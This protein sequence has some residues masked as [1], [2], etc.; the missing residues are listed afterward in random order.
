[1]SPAPHRHRAV[2]RR[3]RRRAGDT[4][5]HRRWAVREI[6]LVD[7]TKPVNFI[8]HLPNGDTVPTT[9]EPGED[10]SFLPI[11][12]P[13]VWIKQGDPTVYTAPPPL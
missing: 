9:R 12:S 8:M 10:R 11:D 7:D 2:V 4:T 6:P 3:G 1:M 13:Q 5:R